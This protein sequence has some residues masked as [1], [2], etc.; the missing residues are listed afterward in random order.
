MWDTAEHTK[1]YFVPGQIERVLG[2]MLD[3]FYAH[4]EKPVVFDKN[5]AWANPQNQEMLALALGRQ[6]KLVCTVR[7]IAPILASF[8]ALIRKNP[9]STSFIDKELLSVGQAL[10]DENRC[11]LLM[12]ESGHVF[13]SWSVLRSGVETYRGNILF[14]EYDNLMT[15]PEYELRRI[16]AFLE[17][18][19]FAHNLSNIINPV[20]ENDEKAYNMPGMHAVRPVLQKTAKD[21]REILGQTLFDRYQGGEFWK[22]L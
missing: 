4:I 13:Q 19:F 14:V 15:R 21:P 8:I 5:R 1:A 6:P 9:V 7:P 12:S 16:Y 22:N 11:N 2:G 10:T 17:R 18:P 20:L 3:S